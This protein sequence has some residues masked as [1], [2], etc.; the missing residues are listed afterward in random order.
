MAGDFLDKPSDFGVGS[1]LYAGTGIYARGG[2]HYDADGTYHPNK[3]LTHKHNF[4]LHR[5]LRHALGKGEGLY[6]QPK[7]RGRGKKLL[8]QSFTPNP[9]RGNQ[10]F[11]K[12]ST[13]GSW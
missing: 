8:D 5:N 1:G 10:V 7:V 3:A 2:G 12:G 4:N 11:Q 9:E 13:E 6:A